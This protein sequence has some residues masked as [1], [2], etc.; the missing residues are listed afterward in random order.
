MTLVHRSP[1]LSRA[2]Q[3]FC[4]DAPGFSRPGLSGSPVLGPDLAH[5]VRFIAV[6]TLFKFEVEGTDNKVRPR[7]L[8]FAP[9]QLLRR[10]GYRTGGPVKMETGA[11]KAAAKKPKEGRTRTSSTSEARSRS[12]STSG[13]RRPS[14]TATTTGLMEES[15]KM[16][17]LAASAAAKA[18]Q[19]KMTD[20]LGDKSQPHTQAQGQA[21]PSGAGELPSGPCGSAGDQESLEQE[22]DKIQ[23]QL[24]V[25]RER[26]ELSAAA[27]VLKKLQE[28]TAAPST[29]AA[30]NPPSGGAATGEASASTADQAGDDDGWQVWTNRRNRRIGEQLDKDPRQVREKTPFGIPGQPTHTEKG[31]Y[32]SAFK[33]NQAQADQNRS[34]KSSAVAALSE[35]QWFWFKERLCLSC[36]MDHQVKDCPELSSREEGY[37][38]LKAAWGC[39][40]DQRPRAGQGH[41][42]LQ[43]RVGRPKT[44]ASSS[45]GGNADGGSE[46]ARAR[47]PPPPTKAP[48]A[49]KRARDTAP[50]SSSGLTPEAKKAK[51]FSEAAKAEFTL[52]VRE[53]DGSALTE[54]RYMSLKSSFAYFVEDML[55][56]D[57]DPPLCA[58]RW[59]HSRSVVKI[60]MAGETDKLWMRCFLDKAYLVQTEAEF[61]R[62]KGKIYV[63]YLRD[64]LEPELTGMRP[65]KLATFVRFYKRRMKIEGLFDLKMA[66]KTPKGK[67]I[68]LVMDDKAE[69]VF[70]ADGSRIPLAG[71]G[72]VKFED[73]ATYVAR[74]KAQERQKNKPKPSNLEKGI[75]AQDMDVNKMSMDDDDEVVE[76][77]RASKTLESKGERTKGEVAE[78]EEKL[79]KELLTQVRKG[80]TSRETAQ[81]RFMEL[82]GKKL[83]DYEPSRRTTSSSSWS[84]EVD[85]AK[86]LEIPEM[87]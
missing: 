46:G 40:A 21:P 76:I 65:D 29:S 34:N 54:Q 20:F 32:T 69:E 9:K 30:S 15:N 13:G 1:N 12:G 68:H 85:M 81:A 16:K 25:L 75:L 4:S 26:Q 64:R 52:F 44:G 38:V 45:G 11:D 51:Q 6:V 41:R 80:C 57:K 37:A 24:R 14:L 63:A 77:G 42:V 27:Q 39:P 2:E 23:E 17:T 59:T 61:N 60:P 74:I 73:R 83:E 66:A 36:G 55:S 47:V 43:G 78:E 56:K 70:V 7:L 67:A 49:T 3:L 87:V 28:K 62:S 48:E 5:E 53:K 22:V 18:Q 8:S 84:E 72:W 50:G 58:G 86:S 33:R 82:T 79:T 35:K 71:A 31:Y 10:S 19:R